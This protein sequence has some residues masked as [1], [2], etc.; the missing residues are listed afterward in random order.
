MSGTHRP[1]S[2]SEVRRFTRWLGRPQKK[3]VRFGFEF[4]FSG[5]REDDTVL[6]LDLADTIA[7]TAM[8][9]HDVPA[10]RLRGIMAR[11]NFK[12]LGFRKR[13]V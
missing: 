2:K 10:V 12:T 4:E 1:F 6:L 7:K 9:F 8:E 5:V 11:W 3:R 13:I